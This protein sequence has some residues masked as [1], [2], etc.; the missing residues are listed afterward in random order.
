MYSDTCL[1]VSVGPRSRSAA[2]SV[3]LWNVRLQPLSRLGSAYLIARRNRMALRVE[4]EPI[5]TQQ[6][7]WREY[8]IQVLQGFRKIV[9]IAVSICC[10]PSTHRRSRRHIVLPLSSLWLLNVMKI[11]KWNVVVLKV[12]GYDSTENLPG[13]ILPFLVASDAVRIE[14]ALNCLGKTSPSTIDYEKTVLFGIIAVVKIAVP[15]AVA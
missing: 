15:C 4:D 1:R 14:Q 12:V 3:Y 8:Q 2:A 10:C 6:V 9:P 5:Q 7:R 11:C 13:V